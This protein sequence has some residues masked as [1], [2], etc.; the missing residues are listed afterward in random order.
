MITFVV[1]NNNFISRYK[2]Y[3]KTSNLLPTFRFELKKPKIKKLKIYFNFYLLED[4]TNSPTCQ[5]VTR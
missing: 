3:T 4:R 5:L 1:R 2:N